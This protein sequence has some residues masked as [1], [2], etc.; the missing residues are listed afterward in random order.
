MTKARAELARKMSVI[1]KAARVGN[2]AKSLVAPQCQP[3]CDQTRSMIESQRLDE[4]AAGHT[5]RDEQL[6]E[7]AGGYAGIGRDVGRRQIGI[8]ESLPDHMADRGEQ[9]LGM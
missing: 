7:V 9:L 5:A 4:T 2:I 6:L 3:A 1:E 8:R